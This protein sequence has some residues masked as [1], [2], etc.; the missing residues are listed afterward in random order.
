M[1]SLTKCPK[2]GA[3]KDRPAPPPLYAYVS[4][5]EVRV[6]V[7][8]TTV[9]DRWYRMHQNYTLKKIPW[10]TGVD[11]RERRPSDLVDLGERGRINMGEEVIR[12]FEKLHGI[13][14][15]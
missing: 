4:R 2:S 1:K 3:A 11:W 15:I 12:Y 5:Y 9:W 13:V 10:T 14:S 8:F 6:H 7:R